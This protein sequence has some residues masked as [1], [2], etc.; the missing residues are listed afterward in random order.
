MERTAVPCWIFAISSTLPLASTTLPRAE[1]KKIN[2]YPQ[3]CP[4]FLQFIE[5]DVR[6]F[7]RQTCL[8]F[9]SWICQLLYKTWTFF[10]ILCWKFSWL[11]Y[12][13]YSEVL[14]FAVN[15]LISFQVSLFCTGRDNEL[16]SR[17]LC[18]ALGTSSLLS[19]SQLFSRL[20]SVSILNFILWKFFNTHDYLCYSSH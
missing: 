19:L 18:Q 16:Y 2:I 8:N 14:L 9:L 5:A 4:S 20:N 17:S 7:F 13:L 6:I 15:L 12:P 1:C 10:S 11:N 3:Y